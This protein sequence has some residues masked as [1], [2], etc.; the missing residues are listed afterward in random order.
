[1]LSESTYDLLLQD[2]PGHHG[3]TAVQLTGAS[4]GNN[5]TI[6]APGGTRSTYNNT[7]INALS[8]EREW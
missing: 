3:K 7:N 6:L 1:M 4:E 2:M 5:S 8:G